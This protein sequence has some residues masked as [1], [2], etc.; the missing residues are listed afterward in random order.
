MIIAP[1]VVSGYCDV[2]G[3]LHLRLEVSRS[4]EAVATGINHRNDNQWD[5]G[6]RCLS[7][8]STP[9]HVSSHSE[10][11][12]VRDELTVAGWLHLRHQESILD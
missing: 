4:C 11:V 10:E 8:A 7:T 5:L 1:S 12:L 2:C 6:N 3:C 9:V